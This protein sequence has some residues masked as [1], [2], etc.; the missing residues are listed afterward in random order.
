LTAAYY[1]QIS[2]AP[3]EV[4]AQRRQIAL[5]QP[6]LRGMPMP[7]RD[8]SLCLIVIATG[9]LPV[10]HGKSFIGA[11]AAAG[12]DHDEKAV[13]GSAG[14]RPDRRTADGLSALQD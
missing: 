14:F 2:S 5:A 13:E 7:R 1:S 8:E 10:P 11:G 12:M 6:S 4:A 3:T 9:G